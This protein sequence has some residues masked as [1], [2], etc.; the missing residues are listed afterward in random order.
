MNRSVAVSSIVAAIVLAAPGA[1]AQR[2][3]EQRVPRAENQPWCLQRAGTLE[4]VY[5][6][7]AEC[8][9]DRMGEAP[10]C[11]PNP[12]STTGV[13]PSTGRKR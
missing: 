7:L 2:Q 12:R 11:V 10:G 4:C 6:T 8:N 5:R 9:R 1:Y 3:P 13:G